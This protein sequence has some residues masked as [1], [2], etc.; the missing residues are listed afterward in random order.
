MKQFSLTQLLLFIT[1]CGIAFF[2]FSRYLVR[3]PYQGSFENI[4]GMT[5]Y[6][7]GL[8]DELEETDFD[9]AMVRRA[10]PW[11]PADPNPPLSA[12]MACMSLARRR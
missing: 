5:F 12:R 1:W 4:E 3:S 7:E 10:A 6:H 9:E 2:A 11:N 8:D